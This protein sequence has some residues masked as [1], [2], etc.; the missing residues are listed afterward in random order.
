MMVHLPE[1]KEQAAGHYELLFETNKVWY[2]SKE[3]ARVLGMSVQ[4]VRDAF[5]SQELMGQEITSRGCD[6]TRR[7]KLIHRDCLLLYLIQT[8]NYTPR[9]FM[10]KMK[11]L[12][13]RRPAAELREMRAWLDKVNLIGSR[14]KIA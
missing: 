12:I 13:L 9:D 5:Q 6:G 14:K 3:A 8:A 2:T 11:R 10:D 4:F 7:Y 1:T